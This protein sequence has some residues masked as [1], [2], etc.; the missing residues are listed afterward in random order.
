MFKPISIVLGMLL[1]ILGLGAI[2]TPA[3]SAVEQRHESTF[4]ASCIGIGLHAESYDGSVDNVW[5]ITRNGVTKTGTFGDSFDRTFKVRQNGETTEWS[6]FIEA[7]DGSYHFED[8]GSIGPC[9]EVKLKKADFNIRR[10][11]DTVKVSSRTNVE[12][13]VHRT[14]TATK[15]V[16]IGYAKD[17]AVF[18]NGK[19]KLKKVGW[20]RT[21][22]DHTGS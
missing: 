15:H 9:G 13:I 18:S 10:D 19:T 7:A 11:C 5:S 3:T 8:S 16:F 20:E 12:R 6:A 4:T 1:A 17:G 14:P 22:C 2:M 21:R